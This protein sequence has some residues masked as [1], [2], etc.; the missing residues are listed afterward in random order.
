MSCAYYANK[1]TEAFLLQKKWLTL[2]FLALQFNQSG[3]NNM[4]L[5][6]KFFAMA[7]IVNVANSSGLS[8]LGVT[9]Y[10][11]NLNTTSVKHFLHELVSVS[12]NLTAISSSKD[13]SAMMLLRSAAARSVHYNLLLN[14]DK[15]STSSNNILNFMAEAFKD[16]KKAQLLRGDSD[17]LS[18]SLPFMLFPFRS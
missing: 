6:T 14:N 7:A 16:S 1:L 18:Y 3:R 5:I 12:S 4:K 15:F 17:R 13:D 8:M 9:N 11:M 2:F 10:G